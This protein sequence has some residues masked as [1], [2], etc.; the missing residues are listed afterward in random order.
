MP[1]TV[2]EM[3]KYVDNSFHAL[4]VSFANE[5]GAICGAG[6]DSHAVMDVFLADTKLNISPAYLR[7]G[8]RSE[9]RACPRMSEP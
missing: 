1:I 4:K 8:S 9:V 3:T 5:I 7:P 2:A 6:L